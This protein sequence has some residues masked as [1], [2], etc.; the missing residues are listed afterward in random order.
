[1]RSILASFLVLAPFA[2]ACAQEPAGRPRDDAPFEPSDFVR[3]VTE[4]DGGHLDTAITT[5]RKGD[6]E[7]RLFGAVHIADQTCYDTLNDRFTTCD[8]LLYELVGPE[9]Y[10]PTKDRDQNGLNPI[11]MLQNGLKNALELQ[12]QLDGID[13]SPANFVHADMTPQ[14]FAASMAERGESLLT[15]MLNMMA[16]GMQM[17]RDRAESGEPAAAAPDLVTAFRNGEGRHLLRMSFAA[18]MEQIEVMAVG[19]KDGSTL[20][21]GRNEKC[22]QVL[23]RELAAGKKRIGIYYGAAHLPHMERRLVQDLGFEKTGQ[24]WLV[25]WDCTKRPDKKYDRELYAQRRRCKQ[26]LGELAAAAKALRAAAPTVPTVQEL[27]AAEVGGARVYQGPVQDPW[28]HDYVI[29]ARP[30]GVRWE[31]LSLGEDGL[32]DTDDDLVAQEPRRR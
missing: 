2:G 5:Y 25:A 22:L 17:Q 3:F 29:R 6:V 27:A 31:V 32:A 9:N 1:M 14:E 10:R 7:L 8:A 23:Q 28:G 11:A 15:I 24:E 18:Q 12:F 26:E 21:E 4:G 16:S 13:Y 20:L 30:S 19:G